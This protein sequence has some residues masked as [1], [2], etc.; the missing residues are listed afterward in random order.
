[1]IKR[2]CVAETAKQVRQQQAL[3]QLIRW[4]GTD[5]SIIYPM[6]QHPEL[7]PVITQVFDVLDDR[8]K[9]IINRERCRSPR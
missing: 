5:D 9:D 3:D 1:V 8:A 2:R 4:E 6:R 7:E